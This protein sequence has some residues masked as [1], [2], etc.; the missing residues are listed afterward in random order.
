MDE[1]TKTYHNMH[2]A[3]FFFKIFVT[4]QEME[5]YLIFLNTHASLRALQHTML[6]LSLSCLPSQ[7]CVAQ[8]PDVWLPRNFNKN[9][10]DSNPMRKHDCCICI[11][12]DRLSLSLVM[13]QMI[14]AP[15]R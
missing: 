5:N 15:F 8:N 10:H 12:H 7:P 1:C 9:S 3:I 4:D 11:N 13:L 2:T 14:C 6:S